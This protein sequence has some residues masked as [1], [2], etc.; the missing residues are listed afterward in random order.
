V[1]NEETPMPTNLRY[2]SDEEASLIQEDD[3]VFTFGPGDTSD[4]GSDLL[5][6]FGSAEDLDEAEEEL[7]EFKALADATEPP[8]FDEEASDESPDEFAV[9]LEKLDAGEACSATRRV[10]APRRRRT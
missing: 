6:S 2:W 9:R 7:D 4:C 5:G 3:G 1:F 8:D 10:R